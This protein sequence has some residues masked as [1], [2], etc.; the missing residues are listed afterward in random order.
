VRKWLKAAISGNAYLR[1]RILERGYLLR[2]PFGQLCLNFVVGR[3][4]GTNRTRFS[5]HYSSRV[6]CPE[7]LHLEGSQLGSATSLAVSGGCYIQAGNGIHI[8]EGTIWAPN[9][10]M[11]SANHD[12]AREGKGWSM[13]REPI[14]I[15]K[16]CWIGANAVILPGVQIGDETVVGAGAVVTKSFP[17][18]GLTLVGNPAKQLPRATGKVENTLLK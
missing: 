3:L 6:V 14:R 7:R 5:V 4:F 16:N 12:M 13:G 9:V 18:G 11:V 2:V 15:G 8:G 10:V 1:N 17:E